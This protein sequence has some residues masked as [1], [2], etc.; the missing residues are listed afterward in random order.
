MP[1]SR[2][3]FCSIA[4]VTTDLEVQPR[5]IGDEERLAIRRLGTI[6]DTPQLCA[7]LGKREFDRAS[8]SFRGL[9]IHTPTRWGIVTGFSH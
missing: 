7:E 5:R 9:R 1:N 3:R 8:P 6:V 4:G 2:I